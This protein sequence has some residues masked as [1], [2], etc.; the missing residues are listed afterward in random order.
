[1]CLVAIGDTIMSGQCCF[2]SGRRKR[3][4]KKKER[5]KKETKL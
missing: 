4:K 5:D 2:N 1:M 3:K